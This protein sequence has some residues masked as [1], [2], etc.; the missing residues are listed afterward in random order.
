MILFSLDD[1]EKQDTVGK[2]L[3]KTVP[4]KPGTGLHPAGGYG[5]IQVE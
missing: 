5:I 3:T 2:T 1:G 4:E